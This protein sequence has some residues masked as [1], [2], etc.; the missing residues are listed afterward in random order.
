VRVLLDKIGKG[1]LE[2]LSVLSQNEELKHKEIV[3]HSSL[4]KGAVS[5]NI[6]K[7]VEKDLVNRNDK[8]SLNMEKLLELY[9]EHL[10]TFLIRDSSEPDQMNDSRTFVKRNISEIMEDQEI[11]N[12]LKTVLST[13][14]ERE[15]LESLNSVF[16]ETDRV[17]R[18]TAEKNETK[19][20]GIVTDKSNTVKENSQIIGEAKKILNEVKE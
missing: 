19:L 15:D 17:L 18:E 8:I 3:R 14:R 20:I 5:N 1:Q 13:S 16:K 9:R 12:T 11:E 7:L 4:S 10:E 6:E 2:V